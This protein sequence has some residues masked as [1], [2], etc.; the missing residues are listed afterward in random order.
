MPDRDGRLHHYA[1]EVG[2]L[3]LLSY[4]DQ[5]RLARAVAAGAEAQLRLAGPSQLAGPGQPAGSGG[6]TGAERARL[7]AVADDGERARRTFVEAN[8]R[9]VMA[10]VRRYPV[11]TTQVFVELVQAGNAALVHAA[12]RFDGRRGVRFSA[13]AEWWVHRAIT[14]R[15]ATIVGDS[16]SAGATS[17]GSLTAVVED[18]WLEPGPAAVDHYRRRIARITRPGQPTWSTT[19]LT[20]ATSRSSAESPSGP[21]P[22]DRM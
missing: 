2:Q 16:L 22:C 4:P 10:E 5:L 17:K 19:S 11:P 9:L 15:W 14:Q 18:R 7:E 20:G 1:Q 12:D 6:V 3:D 21:M 8:L 13:Y